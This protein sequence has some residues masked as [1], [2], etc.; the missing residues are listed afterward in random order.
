VTPEQAQGLAAYLFQ[1]LD[2][3]FAITRKILAAVPADQV[4]FKLGEKGRTTAELMWHMVQSDRGFGE[5]IANLKLDSFA[6]DGA[7]PK[8]AAEIVAAYDRDV[9]PTF[10]KVKSLTPEQLATPVNFMN[11]ANLPVVIYVGW[12]A[13]HMIHHR[14]QLSIY[15][16]AMNAHVPQIYGD[17]ADE[18]F[19]AAATA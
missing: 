17:S 6:A 13:N 7:A 5:G 4:N 19:G 11:F 2:T 15:L 9:L 10:E 3:E 18:P 16:R 12:W 8:T 1:T 14:G